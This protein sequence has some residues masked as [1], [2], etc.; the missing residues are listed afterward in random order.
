[1]KFLVPNYS[2]LQKPLTRGL[3]RPRSPFPLSS[4]EFVEPPPNKIPGYATDGECSLRPHSVFLRR[5][6][7]QLRYLSQRNFW[8]IL[9]KPNSTVWYF[10]QYVSTDS[11]CPTSPRSLCTVSLSPRSSSRCLKL[12]HNSPCVSSWCGQGTLYIFFFLPE[13]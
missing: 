3:P 5:E 8:Q 1:M 11:G 4:T 6:F 7:T 12:Y 9:C 13:E 2:C 10:F